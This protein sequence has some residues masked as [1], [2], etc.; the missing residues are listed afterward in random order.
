MPRQ[1]DNENESLVSF[2]C[3]QCMEKGVIGRRDTSRERISV[4]LVPETGKV[5]L[6]CEHCD[7]EICAFGPQDLANM[8]GTIKSV[9]IAEPELDSF[10]ELQMRTLE[11][12]MNKRRK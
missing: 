7:L 5:T 11:T 10:S 6:W 12:Q 8:S 1:V 4:S 9:L 2:H 3:T